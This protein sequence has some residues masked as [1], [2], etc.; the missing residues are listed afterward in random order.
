[1]E[2]TF[3]YPNL[4][5]GTGGKNGILLAGNGIDAIH[6]TIGTDAVVGRYFRF[7]FPADVSGWSYILAS[8]SKGFGDVTDGTRLALSCFL[9]LNGEPFIGAILL[10]N[11]DGT[12]PVA[13]DYGSSYQD[14]GG[15]WRH[16]ASTCIRNATAFKSQIFYVWTAEQKAGTTIDIAQPMACVADEPRA[17]AP[18]SGEVWPE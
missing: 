3:E 7:T 14:V 9:R 5:G 4:A 13:K 15:G 16:V 12:N 2:Q 6:P 11:N 8:L 17:W 1:M 18:A 10:Q